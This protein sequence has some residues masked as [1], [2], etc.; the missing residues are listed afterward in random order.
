VRRVLRDNEFDAVIFTTLE[1]QVLA[2]LVRRLAPKALRI[3][4][5]ENVEYILVEDE[6]ETLPAAVSPEKRRHLKKEYDRML[7]LESSIW[8]HFDGLWATSEADRELLHELNRGRVPSALIPN[9]MEVDRRP[10]DANPGKSRNSTVLFCGSFTYAPNRDSLA[11]LHGEIWPKILKARPDARLRVIGRGSDPSE[12]SDV[13]A[14]P[15][16]D[17]FGE[18]D[19]VV[20]H[21]RDAGVSILPARFGRGTRLKVLEAM[22]L[23]NPLIST[24]IGVEGLGAV[25]GRDFILAEGSDEIAAAT[26]R[27][28]NDSA[29]FDSVRN[30][31][32][33]FAVENY[34]WSVMGTQM[35]SSLEEWLKL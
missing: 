21:Y 18:V 23:G 7:R 3:I 6:I 35:D 4:N 26:V 1:S 17:F 16:V 31:A 28:M 30:A 25:A 8:K 22:C 34:D 2:S 9:G 19:D 15:S 10:F 20:P 13:R 27:L 33:R 14:D 11:W 5:T 32:R 24:A 12:F 29:Q